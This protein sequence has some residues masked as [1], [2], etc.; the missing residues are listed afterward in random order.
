MRLRDKVTVITGAG[1]GIGR[2]TARLAAEAG[3]IVACLDRDGAAAEAVAGTLARPGLALECDVGDEAAVAAAMRAVAGRLGRI[4]VLC[5]NAGF[6]IQGAVTETTEADWDAILRVN[7]KGVA[8]CAKHA[9]PIMADRIAREGGGGVIVN[10][11]SN[12]AIVGIRDRAAYVATKGAVDALTRA[13]AIDHAAQGIRVNAVA[14]GPTASSYFDS[15]LARAND[16]A[17]FTAAL[18]A[19]SPMN[20]VAQPEEIA[21]AIIFLASDDS[22]FMLGAT[23]VVDGG[24]AIW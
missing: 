16:P 15:M 11:A 12:I 17:A 13:M 8:F 19:R 23:L 5:A 18:A 4:D 6:G 24:H 9:I 3:A 14:P 2:A 10:T 20:R 1:A 7:V 22:S 21:R